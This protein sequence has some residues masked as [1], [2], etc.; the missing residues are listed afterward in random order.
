MKR[1]DIE[2]LSATDV[3]LVREQN[4][5]NCGTAET[6]NG[7]VCVVCDGMGGHTGGQEASRIA[8]DCIIQH[9][10]GEKYADICQAIRDAMEFANMQILGTATE[11][12]ELQGMGT[13]ACVLL[14]QDEQVWIAHVGDSRIYLYVA[15]EK[16][17]HRLTKDHSFVQGLVDQEIIYPEEADNHPDRNRLIKALGIKEEPNPEIPENPILPAKGDIFLICS[18]GLSGMVS[19]SQIEVILADSKTDMQQKEA[20]LM[21]AAKSAGGTDNI[22]FQLIRIIHSPHR[23]SVFVSKS[24]PT[25]AKTDTHKQQWL[26]LAILAAIITASILAGILIGRNIFQHPDNSGIPKP[27][28]IPDQ[29]DSTNN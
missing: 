7:M 9:L 4:E 10:S 19:D 20:V 3:G 14:I 17:L 21:S 6:P 24:Q 13:T 2:I 11:H 23:K 12:P 22:T 1:I 28:T 16:R 8:V 29:Q 5:D 15:K 18:D 26:K 25:A 27:D